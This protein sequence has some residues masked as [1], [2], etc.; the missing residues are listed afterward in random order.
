TR[1]KETLM[2]RLVMSGQDPKI[3]SEVSDPVSAD[4]GPDTGEK[5]NKEEPDASHSQ[6][7]SAQDTKNMPD[8]DADP[9]SLQAEE[10]SA[11]QQ[12]EDAAPPIAAK[13]AGK[14]DIEK[15]S[16]T[17]D[18]DQ[19][20]LL[21]RFDIR[22]VSE[23][24]GEV[25]GRIFTILKPENRSLEKNADQ[26][27]VVPSSPLENGIPAKTRNGQYFSIAH[28]KPVKF[29][30]KNIPGQAFF[31]TAS[32]IIFNEQGELLFKSD[33]DIGEEDLG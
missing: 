27:L 8:T 31:T 20:D 28:F 1:D 15:F 13:E 33:I 18:R 17:R 5:K 21:V 25:S 7:Q 19:G 23:K 16:V 22:N 12:P 32:I 2:A 9:Q 4:A 26:W 6:V 24:P 3:A 30:I 14:V 29:R 11:A 10:R